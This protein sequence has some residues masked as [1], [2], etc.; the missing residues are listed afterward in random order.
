[1]KKSVL[2][3]AVLGALLLVATSAAQ[4]NSDGAGA[5]D[6][7]FGQRG[8]V[9]STAA[10]GELAAVIP[11]GDGTIMA[12][13]NLENADREVT[14]IGIKLYRADGT[15]RPDLIVPTSDASAYAAIRQPDG[16]IVSAGTLF[17][18]LGWNHYV[19]FSLARFYPS[20][21][22]DV[23][24]GKR[25][26]VRTPIGGDGEV[27]YG[28]NAVALQADGKIL[29][30]GYG[31]QDSADIYPHEF[32]IVR[33]T[34]D[35]ASDPS[36]GNGG[37]AKTWFGSKYIAYANALLVQPD[38]KI[39][40][41]GPRFLPTGANPQPGDVALARYNPDGARDLSFGK[42]G[43]V[44]THG[45]PWTYPERAALQ[46]DGKIVVVGTAENA[47]AQTTI[48]L[49]RYLPDGR[50]DHSF[51]VGGIVRTA[52]YVPGLAVALQPDGK[53]VVAG[54]FTRYGGEAA[55]LRFLENGSIDRSFGT[56]GMVTTP[57]LWWGST[58]ALQPDGRIL[59]GGIGVG[60]DQR[61]YY[62]LARYLGDDSQRLS[63][64]TRGAPGRGAG[65]VTSKPAMISCGS[66]C[67][68]WFARGSVVTLSAHARKTFSFTGWRADCSGRRTC[69]LKLDADRSVAAIFRPVCQAPTLRGRKLSGAR[70]ALIDAHCSLGS[71]TDRT[72]T[73]ISA[74]R[75]IGQ[76]PRAGKR[77]L[78]GSKVNLVVSKGKRR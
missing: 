70:R 73:K 65:T 71:I 63:V 43:V 4:P 53:I 51:G 15:P 7:S 30:A 21:A 62:A 14:G 38:G 46:P 59:V 29:A 22:L 17:L 32:A 34:K 36:F 69:S 57:D 54:Q 31:S 23:S 27:G 3:S 56:G 45:A 2:G 26:V 25:G 41:V 28:A 8:V 48:E 16:K 1:M 67:S 64:H 68:A 58:L 61:P 33:Y 50:L 18:N 11:E 52:E 20:G 74:G 76:S 42:G 78:V 66:T 12:I 55:L 47:S 24:F 9:A 35:G 60:T 13:G 39:V 44:I 75:I 40:A 19:G 5:L 77:I 37:M 72:S 10:R 6:P 49:L